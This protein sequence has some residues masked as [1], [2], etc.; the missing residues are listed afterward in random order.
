MIS[1]SESN[2]KFTKSLIKKLVAFANNKCKFNIVWNARNIRLLFQVKV[3]L[4]TTA[5]LFTK[6][7]VRVM[8]TMLVNQ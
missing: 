4:N 1:F 7:T 6:G 5:A 8:K 2:E 3:L